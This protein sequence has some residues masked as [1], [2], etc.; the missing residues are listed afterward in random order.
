MFKR[1][2]I[3]VDGS[4]ASQKAVDWAIQTYSKWPDTTFT[5]LHIYVPEV[6]ALQ[7]GSY[8]LPISYERRKLKIPEETIAFNYWK[9]FPDRSRLDHK[10]LLGKPPE[11]ICREA[12]EG[13]Y[14]VIVLGSEG[15]GV[16]SSVL[17]GSVS[18]KVLHHAH[19]P[20]LVI[21]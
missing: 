1:V 16:V 4:K 3:A 13:N 7:E 8:Y 5:L 9:E 17:L 6:L 12:R 18:A 11:V 21:R 15:H 20:V 10:S 14:D 2:L 19:C